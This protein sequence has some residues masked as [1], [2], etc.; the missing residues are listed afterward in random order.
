MAE[1]ILYE[2]KHRLC[3]MNLKFRK[4]QEPINLCIKI[5]SFEQI[6][7]THC[8]CGISFQQHVN[9]WKPMK[10]DH[11][12]TTHRNAML[13]VYRQFI[14]EQKLRVDSSTQQAYPT[15][16]REEWKRKRKENKEKGIEVKK[17]PKIVE[18]HHDD[19]GTDLSGLG[20]PEVFY[21][22]YQIP[23]DEDNF[24]KGLTEHW[25]KGSSWFGSEFNPV[26]QKVSSLEEMFTMLGTVAGGLDLVE[27]CGGEGRTSILAVRRQLTV[28]EHFDLVT[29]W[30]LNSTQ[31]QEQVLR[32]LHKYRPLVIVMGP[33]CKPFGKL[34][35]YNYWHNHDAWLRSYHEAAPHGRFCGKLAAIQDDNHRY[36][37]CEQPKDSRLFDELPWP[38]ALHRPTI[39]IT[40]VDNVLW[41]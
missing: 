4:M 8:N 14:E 27:I 12:R 28:G 13:K 11:D 6:E 32:Y 24:V 36:F 18:D 38:S 20:D 37:I 31:D 16:E 23:N 5:L 41:D 3:A 29:N 15:E 25:M 34:A 22:S 10:D 39:V 21:N 1:K 9:D 30:D 2:S 17:K 19:C 26:T 35:N 33:M 7:S 40:I